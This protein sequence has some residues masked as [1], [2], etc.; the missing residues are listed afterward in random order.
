MV[1]CLLLCGCGFFFV[2]LLFGVGFGHG[3]FGCWWFF[4]CGVCPVVGGMR[5]ELSALV[6]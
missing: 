4:W 5:V 1:C 6:C 3:G 2:C